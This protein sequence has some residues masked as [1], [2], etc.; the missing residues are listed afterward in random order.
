MG[1]FPLSGQEDHPH[2][3]QAYSFR[4][5]PWLEYS[6]EEDVAFCFPCYLFSKKSSLF[7]LK[8]FRNWK[9]VNSGKDC[10]FLSHVGNNPNSPHNVALR[11]CEDFKKQSYHSDN[12]LSKQKFT[13][14]FK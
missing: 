7:T 2:R 4:T 6:L 3:F 5:F 13:T 8:G 1:V 14:N 11:C 12:V 10:A 9:K